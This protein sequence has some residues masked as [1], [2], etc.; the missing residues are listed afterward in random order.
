VAEQGTHEQLLA[1]KGIYSELHRVQYES[2]ASGA[3]P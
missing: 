3:P 2:T 1:L